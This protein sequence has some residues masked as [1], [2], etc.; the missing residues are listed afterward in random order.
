M[1]SKARGPAASVWRAG[2]TVLVVAICVASG[3]TAQ[4]FMEPFV[5][6]TPTPEIDLGF[7]TA[8][9]V[10]EN[11]LAVGVPYSPEG[12]VVYVYER[13]PG[14]P[15][16]WRLMAIVKGIN[17]GSNESF[18][19]SLALHSETL[20]VGAPMEESRDF[21]A[22]AAYVFYRG[23]GGAGNWG[24]VR[25]L[26][27]RELER[28]AHM[29]RSVDTSDDRIVAGTPGMEAV[30][31]H[32]RDKPIRSWW[33]VQ[34][35]VECPIEGSWPDVWTEDFGEVVR[36]SGR[37]LAAGAWQYRDRE[38]WASDVYV[39]DLVEDDEGDE[40]W[41]QVARRTSQGWEVDWARRMGLWAG[42]LV[43]GGAEDR[44]TCAGRVF[45][46]NRWGKNRWGLRATLRDPTVELHETSDVAVRG[47]TAAAAAS[48]RPLDG[49]GYGYGA[50]VF[51]RHA[52]G[53]DRWGPVARLLSGEV[54]EPA[55][56]VAIGP[57]EIVVG[58]PDEGLVLVYPRAPIAAADFENGDT[59][60]MS[61][62]PGNVAVISPGLGDTEYALEV[63]VD[64]TTTRSMVRARQPFR[65]PTVSLGFDL[66]INR[67]RLG[68]TRVEVLNLYGPTRDLVRLTLE[69]DP[70]RDQYFL[71]LRAWEEGGKGWREVGKARM[72]PLR[73]VR[74]EVEWRAAT[75]PGHENGRAWLRTDG[76]LAVR[77][78]DLDT[79]LQLING[80]LLGLPKG[81][82]G[83]VAGAF[84]VDEI[85]LHR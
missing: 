70:D 48:F 43:T 77:A 31:V 66:A 13:R 28:H 12:G 72:P 57:R 4:E 73:G 33:D 25:T 51:E 85:E 10:D 59:A 50:L 16:G 79:D 49:P 34:E 23:R 53:R 56:S 8:V 15:E 54:G 80:M 40:S 20:V 30:F 29:G 18:G 45:Q 44:P 62:A 60:G 82:E 71:T 14:A 41:Q 7:G 35:K 83:T 11:A 78:D 76:R 68:E 42:L 38:V 1:S 74:I 58:H 17:Q 67:V 6:R 63:S 65:E 19:S 39:F 9:A 46:R 32:E 2:A 22:G 55:R 37:T 81:S 69:A 26:A 24:R 52:G 84:L 5:L 3:A 36:L 21:H 64:G 47:N 75:G 27:P 61:R